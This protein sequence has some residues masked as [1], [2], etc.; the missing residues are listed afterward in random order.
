MEQEGLVVSLHF[1]PKVRLSLF[2]SP[3]APNLLG[4]MD[5][6]SHSLSLTFI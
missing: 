6:Y 1:P 5:N 2:T 3:P 4:D